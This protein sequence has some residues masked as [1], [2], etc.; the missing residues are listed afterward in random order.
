M[1]PAGPATGVGLDIGGTK[2]A[3]ALIDAGGET[4]AFESVPT[5]T[6]AVLQAADQLI[7]RL[8][9]AASGRGL[10]PAGIGV[11]VP[12]LVD[13]EGRVA[14]EA[15]IPGLADCDLRGRWAS[16]APVVVESD[17][18]AAALAEA[19]A[20]AGRNRA[21]F[22]YV[23]VGTGIS[24]CLVIDGKPWAGDGGRAILLGSSVMAECD[25]TPVILEEIASGPALLARY[26]AL[27]GKLATV[28]AVVDAAPD[29]DQAA[30]AISEAARALGIGLAL[31]VNLLDPGLVVV[32][33]GLGSA[34]GRFWEQARDTAREF[35][36]ADGARNTPIV[37]A[38]LRAQAGAVGAGLLG[39][40]AEPH[41]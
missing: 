39:L 28:A 38:S 32:G 27:G 15:V 5:E 34:K 31:I 3:A 14:S 20:G 24:Y 8:V 4:L 19:R 23:S 35:V 13:L 17:V 6:S 1:S 2:I 36:Y 9:L 41:R 11:A 37:R 33:G 18:R 40:E 21:S 25:G 30:A 22:A 7:D 12:E 26:H 10:A 29:D 16:V